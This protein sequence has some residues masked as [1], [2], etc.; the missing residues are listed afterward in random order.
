[1][2]YLDAIII[3]PILWFAYKGF[4]KGLIIELATFIAL[5]LGIYIAGHFS[6][7][8]ADFLRNKMDFHSR[9]MSII[10]FTITFLGVVLL[11]I[12][13]G[14]SLEKVVNVLLLSFVNK[15]LGALFGLL[16]AAFVMSTL[17]YIMATFDFENK[18]IDIDLQKQSLLYKPIKSVAPSIFP[19]IKDSNVGILD[20]IDETIHTEF[21]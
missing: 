18:I 11:V 17:I 10:S 3:I 7:Y 14:K 6:D 2:N 19:I 13:F 16:K 4:T 21:E 15:I 9:Y 5:L 12:L 1:M 20:I 8:T